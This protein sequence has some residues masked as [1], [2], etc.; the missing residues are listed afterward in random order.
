MLQRF[1]R[2]TPKRHPKWSERKVHAMT[3]DVITEMDEELSE[4]A[5]VPRRKMANI[6]TGERIEGIVSRDCDDSV[7]VDIGAASDGILAKG[8]FIGAADPDQLYWPGTRLNVTVWSKAN[9]TV[10]L[11]LHRYSSSMWDRCLKRFGEEPLHNESVQCWN[12][13]R[14]IPPFF[15]RDG[16]RMHCI[17][18][19]LPPT[20]QEKVQALVKKGNVYWN[21]WKNKSSRP[22]Q[23]G[24][25]HGVGIHLSRNKTFPGTAELRDLCN[26]VLGDMLDTPAVDTLHTATNE[27]VWQGFRW[28]K[29]PALPSREPGVAV[30][31]PADGGA[32]Q[33]YIGQGYMAV[34][35]NCSEDHA[36]PPPVAKLLGVPS[37]TETCPTC[38]EE[39]LQ[40]CEE[41]CVHVDNDQS[42][43]LLLGIQEE[44]PVVDEMAFF[45]M[46][47]KAFPLAGGRVFLFDGKVVPHGVWCMKG[48]YQG[49]AFVKK[50]PHKRHPRRK[51]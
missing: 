42:A 41:C 4:D 15:E 2:T 18:G 35:A 51:Q 9:H 44:D 17:V 46:G 26:E 20:V 14:G 22:L 11:R 47:N 49:M 28:Y 36:P 6:E 5:V 27:D 38:R 23:K 7:H 45:V 37:C 10:F 48:H 40:A 12:V 31:D 50:V 43:T 3:L 21:T 29:P 24:R 30:R 8:D 13:G 1:T 16:K 19:T 33:T 32:V 34:L 39:G 25:L